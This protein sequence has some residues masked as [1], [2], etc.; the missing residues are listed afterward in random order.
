MPNAEEPT[1]DDAL[2][3]DA[4]RARAL[5]AERALAVLQARVDALTDR[6]SRDSHTSSR[7]PSSDGLS[8]RSRS[9]PPTGGKR[10][11]QAGHKGHHRPLAK[12]DHIVECRPTHCR[13]CGTE[14]TGEDPSPTPHQVIDVVRLPAEITEYR[15]HKLVCPRC[16]ERTRAERPTGVGASRFG[17]RLTAMVISFAGRWRLGQREIVEAVGEVYGV[18]VSLG[19]VSRMLREGSIAFAQAVDSAHTHIV[20]Q[21]PV[22]HADETP[23]RMGLS[24]GWMWSLSTPTLSFFRFDLRRNRDAAKALLGGFSGVLVTDR[25]GSYDHHDDTR[26]QY[27]WAHIVREFRAFAASCVPATQA[28]GRKLLAPANALLE[29]WAR[30]RAGERSRDDFTVFAMRTHAELLDVLETRCQGPR[31]GT[32]GF[33]DALR[34]AFANF[35]VFVTTA[36]VEPTNNLAERRVRSVVRLRRNALSSKSAWGLLFVSRTLSVT[37]SLRAQ[38]RS[39]ARWITHA[40]RWARGAIDEPAPSL[41]PVT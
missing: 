35:W 11:A 15:L 12:P 13:A 25:L 17:P 32:W 22:A 31:S 23:W 34:S 26:H 2:T 28:L 1:H 30:V 10:G 5:R 14:L 6:M 20:A 37:T 4:W 18:D 29:A 40:I 19:A 8:A 24:R 7:P 16:G 27:C 36:G 38:G 3:L 39:V 9:A 21:S 33:C 41:L